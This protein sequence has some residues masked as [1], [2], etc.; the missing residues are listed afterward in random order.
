MKPSLALGKSVPFIR[1]H[2]FPIHFPLGLRRSPS[3]A[4]KTPMSQGE[5]GWQVR[6]GFGAAG[7]GRVSWSMCLFSQHSPATLR[8]A[9]VTTSSFSQWCPFISLPVY[10]AFLRRQWWRVLEEGPCKSAAYDWISSTYSFAFLHN[11]RSGCVITQTNVGFAFMWSRSFEQLKIG[12]L[13]INVSLRASVLSPSL[14][15]PDFI[16]KYSSAH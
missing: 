2:L 11:T 15:G 12:R 16:V 6:A 3:S 8:E 7:D 10:L 1:F 5:Q 4:S 14:A 13:C 9:L